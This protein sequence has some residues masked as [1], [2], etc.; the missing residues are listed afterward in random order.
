MTNAVVLV[1]LMV[2]V[3]SVPV[4]VLFVIVVVALHFAVRVS[5]RLLFLHSVWKRNGNSVFPFLVVDVR[6]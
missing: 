2:V 1:V 3:A 4:V 6:D 5:Q